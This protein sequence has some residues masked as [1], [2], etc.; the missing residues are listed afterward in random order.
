MSLIARSSQLFITE[1][2]E[3]TDD[4]ERYKD[5]TGFIDGKINFRDATRSSLLAAFLSQKVMKAR[6][7]LKRYVLKSFISIIFNDRAGSMD[8]RITQISLVVT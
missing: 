4:T 1:A 5:Y 7:T 6:M 2:Y 8:I 3:S